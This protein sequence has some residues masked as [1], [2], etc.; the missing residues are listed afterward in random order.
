MTSISAVIDVLQGCLDPPTVVATPTQLRRGLGSIVPE[1]VTRRRPLTAG[2]VEETSFLSTTVSSGSYVSATPNSVVEAVNTSQ[3]TNVG[4]TLQP[5]AA[6]PPQV[7]INTVRRR[8]P[9]PIPADEIVYNDTAGLGSGSGSTVY[10]QNQI[11]S[12]VTP[13][14]RLGWVPTGTKIPAAG[15]TIDQ[16][17]YY[18]THEPAPLPNPVA[19]SFNIVNPALLEYGE[20]IGPLEFVWT[21]D[22]NFALARNVRL[23]MQNGPALLTRNVSSGPTGVT[24]SVTL[25]TALIATSLSY[26]ALKN[27]SNQA[28]TDVT[29]QLLYGSST[30][31]SFAGS[32]TTTSRYCHY[33]IAANSDIADIVAFI[34]SQGLELTIKNLIEQLTYVDATATRVSGVIASDLTSGYPSA[35]DWQTTKPTA[36]YCYVI[37]PDV[38]G[39]PA[40]SSSG[41]PASFYSVSPYTNRGTGSKSN[42]YWRTESV[43]NNAGLSVPYRIY[44]STNSPLVGVTWNLS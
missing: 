17:L 29:W 30:N 11:T 43:A 10:T 3:A 26:D 8:A 21:W 6:C 23:Q 32:L 13:G 1:D 27:S 35:I 28:Y 22:S 31:V 42:V 38:W 40:V 41:N 15:M 14:A 25:D 5:A 36:T 12:F 24:D 18:L 44:R 4:A 7:D 20:D 34:I 33:F 9:G 16:L 39:T 2:P 37:A 19:T